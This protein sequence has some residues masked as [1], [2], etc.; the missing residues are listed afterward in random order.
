M[1]SCSFNPKTEI[2]HGRKET[3]EKS[4]PVA[5]GTHSGRAEKNN[6]DIKGH[7]DLLGYQ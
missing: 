4:S 3:D 1:T 5:K 6:N 7:A 2:C